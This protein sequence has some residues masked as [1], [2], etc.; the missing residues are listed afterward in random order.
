MLCYVD[1][2][3]I[4]VGWMYELSDS[5]L[6]WFVVYRTRHT[7]SLHYWFGGW[8]LCLFIVGE[9]NKMGVF[10]VEKYGCCGFC[11]LDFFL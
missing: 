8:V 6:C 4:E 2:I 11:S 7:E 9:G 3:D 10:F 5:T 1:W